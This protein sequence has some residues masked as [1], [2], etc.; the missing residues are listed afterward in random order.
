MKHLLLFL[1]VASCTTMY[2][3]T[4]N[5]SSIKVTYTNKLKLET[6]PAYYL[7]GKFIGGSL[8]GINPNTIES[9]TVLKGADTINGMQYNGRILIKTK[10][11]YTPKL[12]TLNELKFKYT[13]LADKSVVFM[14][15][16]S[17]INADYDKY[18]VDENNVLQ[19]IVDDINNPKEK[20][21]LELVKVLTKTDENIKKSK[22]IR[23]RGNEVTAHQYSPKHF[24]NL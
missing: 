24:Q 21:Q 22:E 2:A 9:I 8:P 16:G 13:N 10:L 18:L 17:I 4:S 11:S 6:P 15:D 1:F 7:N 20:I 5:D 23:I 3:Q 14:I 12:V 19:I